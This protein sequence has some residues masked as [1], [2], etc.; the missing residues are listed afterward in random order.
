MPHKIPIPQSINYFWNF[1]SLIRT[2]FT[3]QL[4]SGILLSLRYYAGTRTIPF[5]SVEIIIREV[6]IRYIVRRLHLVRSQAILFFIYLHIMRSM[7]YRRRANIIITLQGTVILIATIGAAFLRYVLPWRQISFWGATVITRF[8]RVLPYRPDILEWVWRRFTVGHPTL[9]RFFSLHYIL[10]I[11]VAP[12]SL[13][14]MLLLHASRSGRPLRD[15]NDYYV[16]FWPYFRVKDLWP[17][18]IVVLIIVY[19]SLFLIPETENLKNASS[20]TTPTHIKPEWYF[21]MYYAILR[22]VPSKSIGLM[23]I[24]LSILALIV[25]LLARTNFSTTKLGYFSFS[26]FIAVCFL[27]R[28]LRRKPVE[29]PFLTASRLLSL[30]Y[31]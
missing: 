14:H 21:L 11:A 25:I 31:F 18:R 20:I 12:L 8:L 1:R 30:V 4:V 6:D 26:S 29:E 22:A 15:R 16:P 10:R 9:T 27:L 23:L 28:L 2:V 24:I 17:I 7:L 3:I 19:L 5:Y 13:I